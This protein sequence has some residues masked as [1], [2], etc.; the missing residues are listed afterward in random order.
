MRVR[1]L[2]T[3]DAEFRPGQ[4]LY[5][6]QRDVFFAVQ[7]DAVGT[8]GN[9]GQSLAN[10]PQHVRIAIEIPNGEFALPCQLD[11]IERV[12]RRFDD[13]LFAVTQ[14]AAQQRLL[15]LREDS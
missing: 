10:E 7:T 6:L 4:C 11:R 1:L 5:P 9:S 2:L 3:G 12:G 14:R 13:D 15:D 8:F